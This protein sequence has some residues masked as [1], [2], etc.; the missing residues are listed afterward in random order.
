MFDP[1]QIGGLSERHMHQHVEDDLYYIPKI[2][3]VDGFADSV[4][5]HRCGVERKGSVLRQP[6]T[7]YG[8]L[9]QEGDQVG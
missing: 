4:E 1:S 7:E 6:K 5:G 2:L 8:L 9:R 3:A